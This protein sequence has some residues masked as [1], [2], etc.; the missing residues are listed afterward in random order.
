[1]QFKECYVV[2]ETL[3]SGDM[4]NS[5][6]TTRALAVFYTEESANLYL[7]KNGCLSDKG[8]SIVSSFIEIV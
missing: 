8:I 2:L 1:M 4:F 5:R 7:E 6:I 3:N